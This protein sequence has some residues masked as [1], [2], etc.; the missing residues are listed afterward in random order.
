MNEHINDLVFGELDGTNSPEQ[1]AELA[2]LVDGDESIKTHLA[3]TKVLFG[4]LDQVAEVEPPDGLYD[5]IMTSIEREAAAA[6]APQAPA[7]GFAQSIKDLF[8]PILA[9][10]A[11]AMSYAFVAGLLVG[12]VALTVIPGNMSPD[13]GAVQGTIGTPYTRMLDSAQLEV[14]GITAEIATVGLNNEIVLDVS[15]AGSGEATVLLK[16]TSDPTPR[17]AMTVQSPAHFT[18]RLDQNQDPTVVLVASGQ[19]QSVQ[20]LTDPS[21]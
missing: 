19:E 20:L 14:A 11:W 3:E 9:R 8:S 21:R 15:L 5:R 13:T 7:T 4:A 16:T 1:S 17:A 18:I 6:A 2:R 10:P 12:F